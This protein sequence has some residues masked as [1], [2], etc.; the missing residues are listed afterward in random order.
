MSTDDETNPAEDDE[1]E[2]IRERKIEQ[3][4]AK[5]EQDDQRASSPD[6][7]IAIESQTHFEQVLQEHG[8]VLVDFY[9]DWCG[10]CQMLAPVLD[11]LAAE[12]P[13]TIAKVDT[14]ALP[15]VAQ[16]YGVRGLPTLILFESGQP[17]K[18]LVGMQ[19]ES[20]LRGLL[21]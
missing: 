18:Q 10:P 11:R 21:E 7:P 17:A 4:K 5:A 20:T 3:L 1:L 16:Q 13:G 12:T 8:R 19:D 14:E 15:G 2:R 6:Q 9:A